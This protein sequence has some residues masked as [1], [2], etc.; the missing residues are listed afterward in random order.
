MAAKDEF[1]NLVQ[2]GLLEAGADVPGDFGHAVD[3]AGFFVLTDGHR[4]GFAHCEQAFGAV[5]AHAGQDD[6]DRAQ[7]VLLQDGDRIEQDVD[8]WAVAVDAFALLALQK[9]LAAVAA[10]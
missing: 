4:A 10:D 6:A 5:V 3:N 1:V 2:R 8:R 9:E 7:V